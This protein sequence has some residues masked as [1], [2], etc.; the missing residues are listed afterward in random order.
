[1]KHVR[2]IDPF[3]ED[4]T[5]VSQKVEISVAMGHFDINKICEDLFCGVFKEL[6][7]FE[8][9]RNLNEE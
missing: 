3:R 6:Y 1:M 9:L 7:G 8:K 2:V 4:L 5:K